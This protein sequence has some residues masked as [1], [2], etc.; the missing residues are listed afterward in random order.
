[1]AGRE[2]NPPTNS[3]RM[4]GPAASAKSSTLPGH[5]GTA[6][7]EE[8]LLQAQKMED[9]GRLAGG[10]ADDF[11]NLLDRGPGQRRAGEP[12]SPGGHRAWARQAALDDPS[13]SRLS[14]AAGARSGVRLSLGR[15]RDNRARLPRVVPL[16]SDWRG[17]PRSGAQPPDPYHHDHDDDDDCEGDVV[18]PAEEHVVGYL[19]SSCAHRIHTRPARHS[20][21]MGSHIRSVSP[22]RISRYSVS[23][24]HFRW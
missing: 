15:R 1:M 6:A 16:T 11:H 13:A 4:L 12:R 3:P 21:S 18:G 22:S 5:Q 19:R 8:Q 10:V 23:P 24:P 7:L 14:D 9:V 20:S 2:G 17:S